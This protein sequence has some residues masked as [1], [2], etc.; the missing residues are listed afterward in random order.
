[1]NGIMIILILYTVKY[2][3]VIDI[4]KDDTSLKNS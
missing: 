3:S 4:T 1:M 2:A